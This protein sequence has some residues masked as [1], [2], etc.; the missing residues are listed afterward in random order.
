MY[1]TQSPKE[2][3]PACCSDWG[4][5]VQ[6]CFRL[7]DKVF[8]FQTLKCFKIASFVSFRMIALLKRFR[9]DVTEVVVMTDT[10][11]SPQSKKYEKLAI[12][13]T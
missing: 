7:Y 3:F 13:F 9:I 1:N 2:H 12:F 8:D 6:E 4:E 5:N 10:E 11:R